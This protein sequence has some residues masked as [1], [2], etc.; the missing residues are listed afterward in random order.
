M[1][2]LKSGGEEGMHSKYRAKNRAGN[3]A[4]N[5]LGFSGVLILG[6]P[7]SYCHGYC[8]QVKQ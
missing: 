8:F 2:V 5:R 6:A 3:R 7:F 1:T 4:E